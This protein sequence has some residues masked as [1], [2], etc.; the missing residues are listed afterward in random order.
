L[1]STPYTRITDLRLLSSGGEDVTVL[2]FGYNDAGDL[3][4]VF[5][6]SNRALRFDYDE[7]GRIT[8]WT[9]RNGEWY[10]YFYDGDGR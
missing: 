2:R 3:S 6:S 7:A 10:R 1:R 5:N 4:T 9:D 8:Q